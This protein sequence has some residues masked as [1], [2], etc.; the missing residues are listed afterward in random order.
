MAMGTLAAQS[1]SVS[2]LGGIAE[3]MDAAQQREKHTQQDYDL[4]T[5]ALNLRHDVVYPQKRLLPAI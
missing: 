3:D 1:T 2:Y 5:Q 4:D